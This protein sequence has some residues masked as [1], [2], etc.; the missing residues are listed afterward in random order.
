MKPTGQ[1]VRIADI[2]SGQRDEMFA[3]M[4]AYY[5]FADRAIFE[6]DLEEKDWVVFIL[7]ESSNRLKGFSTQ[8]VLHLDVAG[9]SIRAVFSG[10]TIIDREARGQRNLFQ[11]SGWLLRS[12]I[13]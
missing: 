6:A 13:S 7:D 12:L 10:D 5:D 4:E 1:L 9:R 11:V 3:L 8:M 2:S